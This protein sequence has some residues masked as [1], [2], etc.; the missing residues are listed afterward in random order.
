MFRFLL[1]ILCY[2]LLIFSVLQ[3][4]V[5]RKALENPI[6]ERTKVLL[7]NRYIV[8]AVGSDGRFTE[9]TVDGRRLLYGFPSEGGPSA[10]SNT[11]FFVDGEF[12]SNARYLGVREPTV[13][14]ASSVVDSMVVTVW[15]IDSVFVTQILK[16]VIVSTP[17]DET[18]S[19]LIKYRF[20]N[21]SARLRHCGVRL[22]LDTMINRNDAAPIASSFGYSGF[23]QD[24]RL[25]SGMPDFWRAYE[26]SPDQP[27]GYLVGEGTLNGGEA[28]LPDRFCL[29]SYPRYARVVWDYV[30]TGGPYGDSAVLLWWYP[31]L[32][33]PGES[34]EVATYYGLGFYALVRGRLNLNVMV[35]VVYSRGCRF[36]PNPFD[37]NL[38]VT[39]PNLS[40]V[41]SVSATILLPTGLQLDPTEHETHIL[42]PTSIPRYGTG[43]T[44]WRPFITGEVVDDTVELSILVSS[45]SLDEP[46]TV[47]TMLYVPPLAGFIRAFITYPPNGVITSCSSESIRFGFELD[48]SAIV[49]QHFRLV[50]NELIFDET[51][52]QISIVGDE[53]LFS[54]SSPFL[55]GETV[56]VSIDS[57]VDSFGCEL[58]EPVRIFFVVDSEG[59]FAYDPYPLP[60]SVVSDSNFI[61]SLSLIDNVTSI[62]DSSVIFLV[63]RDSF[64]IGEYLHYADGRLS[65]NSASLGFSDGE[66]I[67]VCL[68]RAYDSPDLCEP[69]M[70]QNAPF[71]WSFRLE[72][73]DLILPDTLAFMGDT[74][75]YPVY[76]Q[77]LYGIP[78][79]SFEFEFRFDARYIIP[80]SVESSSGFSFDELNF[81]LFP[82]GVFVSG[83]F[84]DPP[85]SQGVLFYIKFFV[86]TT[87][88]IGSYTDISVVRGSFNDG[89]LK[90]RA[91]TGSIILV[92]YPDA[93]S[94]EL[95]FTGTGIRTYPNLLVFGASRYG[96]R[97]FDPGLDRIYVPSVFTVDA[98]FP[99]SDPDYPYITRL[100]RDIR[101]LSDSIVWHIETHQEPSG[102]VRWVPSLLPRTGRFMLNGRIDMRADSVYRFGLDEN[103]T[104]TYFFS[105]PS[106]FTLKLTRGWNLISFPLLPPN[107]VSAREILPFVLGILSYS[108]SIG[109]YVPELVEFGC[110]YWVFSPVDTTVRFGGIPC[111][112]VNIPIRSGWNL[113]GFT[114]LYEFPVSLILSSP[115]GIIGNLLAFD[116]ISLSYFEPEFIK[117]GE[118]Y[119][120]FSFGDGFIVLDYD[121][122]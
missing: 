90:I 24:F 23:E 86:S 41:E 62:A 56:Y 106:I 94:F 109:Y 48:S 75:L 2:F 49:P 17:S 61:I 108:A 81:H 44:S 95:A 72:L 3:A 92:G 89:F 99:L 11:V 107:S 68:V 51:S 118:G 32:L 76:V 80:I 15:E 39:N 93:W 97:F 42:Q 31:R 13:F 60:N 19:L 40:P 65:F 114:S 77:R 119:W 26:F 96:S 98:Y 116:N 29:G 52:D 43:F 71:C 4:Q 8:V 112:S 33:S 54:P 57:A 53:F 63:N 16:P 58:R 35:P 18:G 64:R 20:E 122:R 82:G 14:I 69:N 121:R 59:P 67:S 73:I 85:D 115:A 1:L 87:G 79:R 9:G 103:L 100:Q 12:Y 38:I 101:A 78:A 104:V 50:V 102:L 83:I 84:E 28:V 6:D 7:S 91:N 37:I 27:P 22:L 34:F 113:V 5:D 117:P 47:S 70:L 66:S 30:A 10:T 45:P 74:I 36:Y 120:I 46:E 110:G 88:Y 105:M 21:R 55:S 25:V 111:S